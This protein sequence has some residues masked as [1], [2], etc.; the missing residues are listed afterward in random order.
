MRSLSSYQYTPRAFEPGLDP[1]SEY[2]QQEFS[3]GHLAEL[4]HENTKY[5]S[6]DDERIGLAVQ[7][8]IEDESM[9][10]A[11]SKIGPDYR[12]YERVELPDPDRLETSLDG[13]LE[14]RRSVRT[15]TGDGLTKADLAT[16][17][18]RSL[19]I[20][21]EQSLTEGDENPPT[22][23]FRAYPSGGGL[24]PIEYYVVVPTVG[25][26]FDAGVYYYTPTKHVL[27]VLWRGGEDFETRVSELFL[28][29]DSL[30]VTDAGAILFMTGSIRRSIAKYGARG[31]RLLLQESGHACQNVLLAATALGLGAVPLSGVDDPAVEEFLDIDG[32][33]E[34]VVY[35]VVLGHP[36]GG[37]K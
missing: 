8:F 31:Y 16:V 21:G 18:G 4:F 15:Y 19:G 23:R 25:E 29:D 24:Y 10:Y 11:T 20:T 5:R 14:S 37:K 7:A 6:Y 22:Q 36:R 13:V 2:R 3:N 17:L 30:D 9:V 32:V 28:T 1:Y 35:T 34:S 26:A 12:G 33:D 27:R